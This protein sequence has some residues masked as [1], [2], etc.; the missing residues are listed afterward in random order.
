MIEVH[1]LG[2]VLGPDHAYA[3]TQT[4]DAIQDGDILVVREAGVVGVMVQAWP[5]MVTGDSG[6]TGFHEVDVGHAV[7]T[8]DDGRYAEAAAQARELAD[9]GL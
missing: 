5:V 2:E 6:E 9:N 7:E 8:L 1:Y 3:E 4:N